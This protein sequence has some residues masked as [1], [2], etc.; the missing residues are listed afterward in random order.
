MEDN[1]SIEKMTFEEALQELTNLVKKLDSDQ[2][3][4]SEA[5]SS[6]E[7]GIELKTHCEKKL[8]EAKIKVEKIITDS[9]GNID[10]EPFD[11]TQ[12]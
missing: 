4:L 8:Q 5:I 3:G 1:N 9:N 2:E 12:V 11:N 10:V 7:R 6:F